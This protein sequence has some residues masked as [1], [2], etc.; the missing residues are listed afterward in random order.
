MPLDTALAVGYEA[1]LF[2]SEREAVG[3]AV[4]MAGVPLRPLMN[5]MVR[6]APSEEDGQGGRRLDLSRLDAAGQAGMILGVIGCVGD[7]ARSLLI[8][9]SAP[10]TLPCNCRRRCCSRK[11]INDDWRDA[12]ETITVV[13]ERL[14]VFQGANPRGSPCRSVDH[15]VRTAIVVKVFSPKQITLA[16]ISKEFKSVG[17]DALGRHHSAV[18]RWLMGRPGSRDG[19]LMADPGVVAMAWEMADARLRDAG[20]VG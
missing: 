9:D 14:M 16:E 8:A 11:M 4:R 1:P 15:D 18:Y 2:S 7:F 19:V 10:K 6:S 13:A 5:R 12:V 20:I 3:F 17:V